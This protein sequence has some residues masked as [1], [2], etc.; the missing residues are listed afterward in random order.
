MS[1][2][3]NH[4]HPE[5]RSTFRTS[6]VARKVRVGPDHERCWRNPRSPRY[7][8]LSISP[9]IRNHLTEAV[10]VIDRW[11]C[12]LYVSRTGTTRGMLGYRSE[13]AAIPNKSDRESI[14]ARAGRVI[15][16]AELPLAPISPLRTRFSY[17]LR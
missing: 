2:Y 15:K 10:K 12:I 13:L 5:M 16:L 4:V 17:T 9:P 8:I 6:G 1:A 7:I 11:I 14:E 3:T